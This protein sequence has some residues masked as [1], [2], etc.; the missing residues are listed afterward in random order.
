MKKATDSEGE[1]PYAGRKK[2]GLRV[3]GIRYVPAP[4]AKQRMARALDVL[5]RSATRDATEAGEGQA[6]AARKRGRRNI[7][8]L[9]G[10][11]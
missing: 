10:E 11:P 7:S 6:P 4:D 2:E 1:S 9:E 3:A 8:R 5:L